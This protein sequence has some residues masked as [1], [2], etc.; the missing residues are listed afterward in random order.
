M[1]RARIPSV[2]MVVLAT[3]AFGALL[4]VLI[5]PGLIG[6]VLVSFGTWLLRVEDIL[7]N[8]YRP[9]L[10]R[11]GIVL[12]LGAWAVMLVTELLIPAVADRLRRMKRDY[13]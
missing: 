9:T 11:I 7:V 13:R 6:E 4:F 2:R 8:P 1:K 5:V 3:W 10:V 12:Y